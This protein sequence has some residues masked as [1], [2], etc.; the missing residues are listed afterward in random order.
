MSFGNP[1][2]PRDPAFMQCHIIIPSICQEVCEKPMATSPAGPSC[3]SF[4]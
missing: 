1:P 4:L 2:K 3:A